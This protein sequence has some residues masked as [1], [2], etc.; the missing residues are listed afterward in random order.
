MSSMYPPYGDASARRCQRCGRPLAPSEVYCGTC[1]EY[2]FL[3]STNGATERAQPPGAPWGGSAPQTFYGGGQPAVPPGPNTFLRGNFAPP[4]PPQPI[5]S[6]NPYGTPQQPLYSTLAPPPMVGF[7]QSDL[8]GYHPMGLHQP[9]AR[10]RVP[11]IGLIVGIL[12]LIIILMIIL[13][14][15]GVGYFYIISHLEKTTTNVPSASSPTPTIPPLFSDSFQNNNNGWD[16]TS[17]SGKYSVKVGGGSMVLEDDDNKLLW[18]LVP[19]TKVY[20]DFKLVVDATLSRGDQSNGYGVFIRGASNQ[21]S[22]LATYYRFELYGD[23]TYAVFKG[24]L[25]A[26]GNSQSNTLVDYTMDPAIQKQGNVNHITIIANGPSMAFI[27]NGQTLKVPTDTSYTGG[28]VALF[29][30]NLPAPTPP[31]AQATFNNLAIYPV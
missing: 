13:V 5:Y 24:V 15:G 27:V 3:T 20:S 10:K 6:S 26:T 16:L 9:P 1:G 2:N 25:D 21:N 4:P 18:E 19:G 11:K 7:Q 22:E 8:N 14:G 17:I 29:V 12:L 23:G 31:G 30:S 28:S